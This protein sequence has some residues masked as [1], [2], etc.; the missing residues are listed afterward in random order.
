MIAN[1]N[2]LDCKQSNFLPD[3]IQGVLNIG[4]VVAVSTDYLVT[5]CDRNNNIVFSETVTSGLAGELAINFGADT[6]GLFHKYFACGWPLTARNL[7]TGEIDTITDINGVTA[8][9]INLQFN[10]CQP[11]SA[12]Y[13]LSLFVDKTCECE[14]GCEC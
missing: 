4:T 8:D 14:A 11:E 2:C 10:P 7:S 9:C 6:S 5:I 3:D 1:L 12:P 13:T